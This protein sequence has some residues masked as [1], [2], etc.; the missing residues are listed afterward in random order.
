MAQDGPIWQGF[1]AFFQS[2]RAQIK[3]AITST[4]KHLDSSA[5]FCMIVSEYLGLMVGRCPQA[6]PPLAS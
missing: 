5:N 3:N 2:F 6:L 1:S 4:A